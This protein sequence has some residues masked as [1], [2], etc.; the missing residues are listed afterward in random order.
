VSVIILSLHRARIT[1][2]NKDGYH[3]E[4]DEL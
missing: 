3:H 4:P 1:T 2:A